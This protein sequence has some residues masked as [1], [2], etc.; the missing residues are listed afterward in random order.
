MG[1]QNEDLLDTL[2]KKAGCTY[3]SELRDRSAYPMIAKALKHIQ[4]EKYSLPE[5]E[6]AIYYITKEREKMADTLQAAKYLS[7][8]MKEDVFF[9][10][11]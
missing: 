3:L 7:D 2:A 9:I 1:K 8:K 10:K 6:E 4:P 5:W 11:K